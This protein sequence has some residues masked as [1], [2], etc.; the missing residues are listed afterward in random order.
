MVWFISRKKEPV[1]N[2]QIQ[3]MQLKRIHEYAP[4]ILLRISRCGC[5]AAIKQM[6]CLYF[7][8]EAPALPLPE[9]TAAE[10]HCNY[11]GI[12][13]RRKHK[14]RRFRVERRRAYRQHPERRMNHGR[15]KSDLL[16][17]YQ[18]Y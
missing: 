18:H 4:F 2:D 12:V 8:D 17:S 10:C 15:R 9:C 7:I 11:E 1:N 16:M 5:K 13:D 3:K 14:S 6:D